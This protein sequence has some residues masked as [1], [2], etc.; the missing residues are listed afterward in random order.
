ME[1]REFAINIGSEIPVRINTTGL[2]SDA[3]TMLDSIAGR[4]YKIFEE[5]GRKHG[6]DREHWLQAEAE[7][8]DRP[9]AEVE[10]S[11]EGV[12]VLVEVSGFA[13]RELEVDLEPQRL[14]IIGK[15][16]KVA[17]TK[18]DGFALAERGRRE[19]LK[20]LE[21]PV[22]IDM[23]HATA[24]LKQGIL[25]LHMKKALAAGDGKSKAASAGRTV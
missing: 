17:E 24:R 16:D 21:L 20:S 6:H 19:L 18:D 8:F 2:T 23:R 4:A 1:Q 12:I 7:L 10:E 14:T 11:P 22:A 15:H 25:E 13:P 3:R 9:F 5:Q